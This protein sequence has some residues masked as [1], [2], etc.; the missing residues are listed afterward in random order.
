MTNDTKSSW[1]DMGGEDKVLHS[2]VAQR[3]A[4]SLLQLKALLEKGLAQ[5]ERELEKAQMMLA[6]LKHGGGV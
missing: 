3:Q 4:K 2:A 1:G 6:R 5:K